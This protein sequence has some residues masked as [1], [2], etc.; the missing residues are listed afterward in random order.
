MT[1]EP[2]GNTSEN[3]RSNAWHCTEEQAE[4][5]QLNLAAP[6]FPV[7][8]KA[9]VNPHSPFDSQRFGTRFAPSP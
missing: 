8:L 1:V 9:G 5:Q 4:F 3:F 2:H 6:Y 7:Y